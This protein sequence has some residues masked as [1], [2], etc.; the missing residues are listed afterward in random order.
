MKNI[1][2]NLRLLKMNEFMLKNASQCQQKTEIKTIVFISVFCD[3]RCYVW[4]V[5]M[6]GFPHSIRFRFGTH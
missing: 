4:S 3:K 2:D 6:V 1:A 5:G